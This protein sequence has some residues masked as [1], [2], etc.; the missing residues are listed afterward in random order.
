MY[1]KRDA[2]TYTLSAFGDS[3][4]HH[5]D[6]PRHDE[7]RACDAPGLSYLVFLAPSI[8]EFDETPI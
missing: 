1:N 7:E 8:P 3:R 5:R 6:A 4:M 2:E